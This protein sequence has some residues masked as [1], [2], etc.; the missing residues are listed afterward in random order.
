MFDRAVFERDG[1]LLIPGAVEENALEEL[2]PLFDLQPGRPGARISTL[3][4]QLAQAVMAGG[5]LGQIAQQILGSLPHP[6]RLLLFDKSDGANWSV[7]WHQD[8]QI[9]VASR[10]EA[11]GFRN[12]TRKNGIDHVEPP[13]EI[14]ERLITLR[15][16]FDDCG[17]DNGPLRTSPGSHRLGRIEDGAVP[18]AVASKP[19]RVHIAHR[20]DVLVLRSCILHASDRAVWASRRRVLHVE[21]SPDSAPGPLQWALKLPDRA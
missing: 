13:F 16:H 7:P 14:L 10:R 11:E 4:G 5:P 8:R 2:S 17:K 18:E 3:S 20:G 19:S 6:V 1:A 12:W 21:Y 9:A 15:L